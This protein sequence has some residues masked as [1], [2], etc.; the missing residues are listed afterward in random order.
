MTPLL[1]PTPLDPGLLRLG[2]DLRRAGVEP[3]RDG[4]DWH[5]VRHGVWMPAAH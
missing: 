4:D 2:A 5:H 1:L 3:T